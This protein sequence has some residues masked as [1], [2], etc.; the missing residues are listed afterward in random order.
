[1]KIS[2]RQGELITDLLFKKTGRDDDEIERAFYALNPHVRG[3]VFITDTLVTLPEITHT[4]N[5]TKIIK[6]WD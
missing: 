4:K 5:I 2:A 1:M 6:S 3:A